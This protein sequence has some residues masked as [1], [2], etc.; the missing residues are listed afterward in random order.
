MAMSFFKA[1]TA[2]TTTNVS[3]GVLQPTTKC[4]GAMAAAHRLAAHVA[5]TV[6]VESVRAANTT[7]ATDGV[8]AASVPP[9]NKRRRS[10]YDLRLLGV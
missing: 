8:I 5:A 9:A 1:F 6:T 2:T 10:E 3:A 7:I 4:G